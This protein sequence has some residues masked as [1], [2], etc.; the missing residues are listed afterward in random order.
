MRR[1]RAAQASD[2][3]GGGSAGS[4]PDQRRPGGSVAPEQGGQPAASPKVSDVD[5]SGDPHT[6][7]EAEIDQTLAD[8]MAASDPPSYGGATGVGSPALPEPTE[9]EAR[10]VR[11]LAYRLWEAAGRPDGGELDFW[12]EAER[13]LGVH[14]PAPQDDII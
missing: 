10:G 14:R 12:L 5:T 8:S 11:E 2:L 6:P 7:S 13:R 9:E 1:Q 4:R 3:S